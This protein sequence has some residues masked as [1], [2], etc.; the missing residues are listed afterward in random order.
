MACPGSRCMAGAK[1]A[2]EGGVHGEVD[3]AAQLVWRVGLAGPAGTVRG[4]GPGELGL[5]SDCDSAAFFRR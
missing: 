1:W 2:A 5:S 3:E 4:S